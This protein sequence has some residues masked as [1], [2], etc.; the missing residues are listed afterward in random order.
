MR[1]Q[2][3]AFLLLLL[4]FPISQ[5]NSEVLC[6]QKNGKITNDSVDLSRSFKVADSKCPRGFVKLLDTST[7]IGPQGA[8]GPQGT[9]GATGATGPQ[10]PAGMVDVSSC[11]TESIWRTTV[12]AEGGACTMSLSC[13]G[14]VVSGGTASSNGS[15]MGDIVV[16]YVYGNWDGS[17]S[18]S[19]VGLYKSYATSIQRMVSAPFDYP[20]GITITTTSERGAGGHL[21]WLSITCCPT[22]LSTRSIKLKTESDSIGLLGSITPD[23]VDG[24]GEKAIQKMP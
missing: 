18:F 2:S 15:R 10:G 13:G 9:Q 20:I 21:P 17:N 22:A 4:L 23:Q 11:V 16:N 7:F 3:N 6:V 14:G 5:S 8:T 12:C 1:K 19:S 24:N